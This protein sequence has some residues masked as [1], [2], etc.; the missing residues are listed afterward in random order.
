MRTLFLFSLSTLLLFS[1]TFA[2][3]KTD[4]NLI[5]HVLNGSEHIPFA[6]VVLKG[7]TIGT[8][9]DETG[10]YRMINLPEG[11]FTVVATA[12][13][14]APAEK[15]I[16]IVLGQTL[17]LNFKMSEDAVGL[18]EVVVTGDR[19]ELRRRE[20]SV[21]VNT[22][23]PKTFTMTQ[24]VVLGEGLNYTPGL[25]MENNCQ[26]CGF[27]QLRINGLEGP[28]SQILV[29]SR[30]IFSG[31]AGVYGLELI[32]SNMVDRVE[33]IRGGGSTLYGSNAIAGTVNL[34]LKDPINNSYEFGVNS[35][36]T[37]VGMDNVLSLTPDNNATF[38]ATAVSSD[39]KTGLAVFGFVRNRDPFDANN[40][41]F[42]ELSSIDN[43]SVGA[44]AFHRF[45]HRSKL[46]VDF[47]NIREGRRGGDK[48]EY[49]AHESNITEA[50]DHSITTGGV[51]YDQF[52]RESDI[53]SVF[54]S[55]QKVDRDSYYGANQSLSSYGATNDLS[56]VMGGQYKM[57]LNGTGLIF[58]F[59]NQG[60]KLKDK[61][62]GYADLE[63]A[64]IVGGELI[65]PHTE[66]IV[67]ADQQQN[68]TG[69]F[70]Q[71]DYSYRNFKTTAGVRYDRYT[72]SDIAK[73]D[74]D[75]SGNVISPRVT[76]MYDINRSIQ[77][78]TSYAK[79]YR[80]PQIFDEDLHV[81]TSATRRVIHQNDPNLIQETSHSLMASAA[82]NHTFGDAV[83]SFLVE[84]F[85]TILQ[86]PFANEF[87]EPNSLGD[88]IYTRVNAEGGA[89]V[90][91]VN[92]EFTFVPSN[93]LSFNAGFTAQESQYKDEREFG[94]KEFFR[95]PKNYGFFAVQV[96]PLKKMTLSATGTYTGKMLVPY[97][98][99]AIYNPEEGELRTSNPFF[100]M[101]IRLS[102]D[103]KINGATM[104][105]FAGAKNIFNSYQSD[106]DIGANRDPGYVYGPNQPR[107]I[108][109]G[110]RIGNH[111]R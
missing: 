69:V 10:H 87:G 66:N 63:N 71:V 39:I 67:V 26:N 8:S 111:L 81:E 90:N 79:G 53:L 30:P 96:K 68:I 61:K 102:Y 75:I 22:V 98:G 78:R 82:Y 16:N 83:A 50:V 62:L 89:T 80:A 13:G 104:Q 31:L 5:G 33:V 77:L 28:Y 3:K 60:G 35:L 49:P 23:T 38:S 99:P 110:I 105:L 72:I 52:F 73:P 37:G 100:D 76:L 24:S 64:E 56:Y 2:Q 70:T 19:N 27:T 85:Y 42:S 101:G 47:F 34:I 57:M 14:Y 18:D 4:A 43:T 20:S 41:G 91:G 54:A 32:P 29:N 51:T 92:L 108:Y 46:S 107:A 94:E 74:D 45:G 84:G 65:V 25:R 1:P 55:A 40:D 93:N 59:E 11:K 48:H 44:R 106:F 7:T 17:E 6:N 58:G 15:E 9:T 21:V 109:F 95:T 86:N 88:V 103:I 12:I 36:L 97:W